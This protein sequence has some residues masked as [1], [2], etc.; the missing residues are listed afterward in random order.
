MH[1]ESKANDK[2]IFYPRISNINPFCS[3]LFFFCQI[4]YNLLNSGIVFS[5]CASSHV[6][7]K[8]F[9]LLLTSPAVALSLSRSET[10]KGGWKEERK[11]EKV[12]RGI[13]QAELPSRRLELHCDSNARYSRRPRIF[14]N[15]LQRGEVRK[16][17]SFDGRRYDKP[18]ASREQTKKYRNAQRKPE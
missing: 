11:H 17:V 18:Q 8:H 1:V 12:F 13:S 3:F 14:R 10:A 2:R 16:V 4:F 15:K 6:A 7:S 5:Q 9:F